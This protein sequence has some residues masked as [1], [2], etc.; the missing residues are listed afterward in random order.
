M[1]GRTITP[2]TQAAAAAAQV[3]PVV[4][5]ELDFDSGS[6]FLCS[7]VRDIVWGVTWKGAG[8]LGSISATREGSEL[9]ADSVTFTLTGI[10]SDYVSLA[11]GQPCQGRTAKVYLGFLDASFALIADPE[12][13]WQGRMDTM[14]IEHGAQGSVSVTAVNRLADWDRPRISRYTDVDQQSRHPGDYGLQFVAQ[15]QYKPI[16]WGRPDSGGGGGG[17]SAS[18]SGWTPL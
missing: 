9:Q 1:S 15:L 8:G 13:E 11:L 7:E 3:R 4:F 2:A 18:G 14:D 6:V 12:L 17:V 10:P 5:V 16:N